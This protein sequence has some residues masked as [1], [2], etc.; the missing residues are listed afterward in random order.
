MSCHL[1]NAVHSSCAV[2]LT[3]ESCYGHRKRRFQHPI[4][5]F[6]S[7]K[8]RIGR[9]SIRAE[10]VDSR[11]EDNAGERVHKRLKSKRHAKAQHL[12]DDISLQAQPVQV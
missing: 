5:G 12:G 9:D 11:C 7:D 4:E 2:I 8:A 1:V 10:C 3:D 6:Y